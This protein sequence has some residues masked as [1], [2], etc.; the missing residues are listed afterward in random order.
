[1]S[2]QTAVHLSFSER[3]H[4][5]FLYMAKRSAFVLWLLIYDDDDNDNI[6][7]FLFFFSCAPYYDREKA[8]TKH[9]RVTIIPY[10]FDM[11]RY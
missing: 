9:K 7:D 3:A 10:T 2:A 5:V 11:M 4:S 1:M 6:A 8:F